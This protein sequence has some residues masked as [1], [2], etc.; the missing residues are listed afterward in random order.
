MANPFNKIR[1]KSAAPNSQ[2]FDLSSN[3]LTTTDFGQL[4]AS[5][6][7]EMY[8]G[9]KFKVRMDSTVFTAP[10]VVPPMGVCHLKSRAFFVPYRL[11][12]K[13]FNEFYEN[14]Q[15]NEGNVLHNTYIP[16]F[17]QSDLVSAF[18]DFSS[19]SQGRDNI[20]LVTEVDDETRHCDIAYLD[21]EGGVAVEYNFT[22]AGRMVYKFLRSLG[23]SWNWTADT[24]VDI[25][26]S[27]LPILCVFKAYLDY[28]V[29]SSFLISHPINGFL[30]EIYS[31]DGDD[32][33]TSISVDTMLN[34]I[35]QMLISYP[36]NY[37][38]SAWIAP[39]QP[40]VSANL[41]HSQMPTI[42]QVDGTYAFVDSER[43][44][45]SDGVPSTVNAYMLRLVKAA[46]SWFKRNNFAGAA[47]VSDALLANFGIRPADSRL[48]RSEFLGYDD[49]I[50]K[51]QMIT[52]T[53]SSDGAELG[54]FG[55]RGYAEG[56]GTTFNFEAKEIGL[57]FILSSLQPDAIYYHGAD[58]TTMQLNWLDF[59]QPS[60]E[61][62]GVAPIKVAEIYS[63]ANFSVLGNSQPL[64]VASMKLRGLEPSRVYGYAPNY[65][66]HKVPH[67]LITG[68][69]NVPTLGQELSSWHFGREFNFG[70]TNAG[71]HEPFD[72][73][74][75]SP[76]NLRFMQN[77]SSQYNRIFN[78]TDNS[79]NHF[80]MV[81]SFNVDAYRPMLSISDSIP[82]DGMGEE[83]TLQPDGTH[84]D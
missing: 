54:S 38:T 40:N 19:A 52:N 76:L 35:T 20:T 53:S 55:A 18:I 72:N 77:R 74:T 5:Y 16:F 65:A 31:D 70:W 81:F 82:V 41:Q 73:F 36:D 78:V 50:I 69:F 39:N 6:Y 71:E 12:W 9:D 67:D 59:Y 2:H 56:N 25:D 75:I 47:R 8:L 64:N 43:T 34:C 29:P 26:F 11:V 62:L 30:T 15:V 68:D 3:H 37:F 10:M 44:S 24:S 60:F 14:K 13:Y 28:Y 7:R 66:S 63:D 48:M 23:Y 84:L 21:S 27:V 22:P 79:A 80:I 32:G 17:R 57:F 4:C 1:L 46:D 42:G 51:W 33:T 83:V 58:K 45:V 49:T 61:K